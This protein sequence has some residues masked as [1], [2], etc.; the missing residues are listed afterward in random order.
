MK[1]KLLL[2]EWER[3]DRERLAYVDV[4]TKHFRWEVVNF[5]WEQVS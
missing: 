5:K 1:I 2:V 4:Q 3:I